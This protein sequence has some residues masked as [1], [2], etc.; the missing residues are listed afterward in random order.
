MALSSF[1]GTAS[2]LLNHLISLQGEHASVNVATFAMV[3]AR[4]KKG[5]SRLNRPF[6]SDLYAISVTD[7]P[8]APY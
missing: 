5:E 1:P 6:A 3:H 7:R 2:V 8:C 4:K